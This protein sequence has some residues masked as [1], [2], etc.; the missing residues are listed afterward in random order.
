MYLLGTNVISEL[1]NKYEQGKYKHC[2]KG[3]YTVNFTPSRSHQ[4]SLKIF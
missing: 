4:K 2:L 1:K 3:V